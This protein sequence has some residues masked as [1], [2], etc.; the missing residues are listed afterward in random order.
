MKK[1]PSIAVEHHMEFN[2]RR[3]F[4][5]GKEKFITPEQKANL[6]KT[7]PMPTLPENVRG[8]TGLG[9]LLRFTIELAVWKE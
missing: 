4:A 2:A 8:F 6:E 3:T 5:Q 1:S 7:Y 9:K